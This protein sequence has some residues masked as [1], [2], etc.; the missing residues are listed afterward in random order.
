MK[1][2][3]QQDP[4][5]RKGGKERFFL[6]ERYRPSGEMGFD[7]VRKVAEFVGKEE[8]QSFGLFLSSLQEVRLDDSPRLQSSAR[9]NV[10]SGEMVGSSHPRRGS[11]ATVTRAAPLVP[12]GAPDNPDGRLVRCGTTK[13][14]RKTN[15]HPPVKERPKLSGVERLN[16]V[17]NEQEQLG[18]SPSAISQDSQ[19]ETAA[20]QSSTA[21][22]QTPPVSS[23]DNI[24]KNND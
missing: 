10:A 2:F 1:F 5:K 8:A 17:V 14:P 9:S 6:M 11:V 19:S 18:A 24:E 15:V 4:K 23:D 3:I 16:K 13:S 12:I 21:S 20:S 7:Q 22:V